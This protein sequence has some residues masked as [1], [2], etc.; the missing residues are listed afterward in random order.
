MKYNK[1]IYVRRLFVGSSHHLQIA[2]TVSVMGIAHHFADP[3]NHQYSET[4]LNKESIAGSEAGHICV[5]FFYGML[6]STICAVIKAMD[7]QTFSI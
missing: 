6:E 2:P 1:F 3:V 5:S 4:F 7:K